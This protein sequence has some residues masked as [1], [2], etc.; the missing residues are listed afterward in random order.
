MMSNLPV[1][2]RITASLVLVAVGLAVPGAPAAAAL[3]TTPVVI[4]DAD[5]VPI[6]LDI[7][8]ASSTSDGQR[9][10]LL[11]ETHGPSA[12][13]DTFFTWYL[14]TDDDGTY[15]H[16]VEAGFDPDVGGFRG[17]VSPRRGSAFDPVDTRR[18][19][20]STMAVVVPLARIGDPQTLSYQVLGAEDANGDLLLSDGELD[21]AGIDGQG[22]LVVRLGGPD[23]IATSVVVSEGTF[24]DHGAQ[25]VVLAVAD[26][27]AD[28]LAGAPLAGA[29]FGPL[30]LTGGSSLD[31]RVEDEIRRVLAPG[32][33]VYLL[34]GTGV[35]SPAIAD[36]LGALGYQVTRY[37]GANR[38]ETAIVIA[39]QGLDNPPTLLLSTGTA[40]VDGLS[41]G[42]AAAARGGALLL[43][44]GAT[45][46]PAVAAYLQAHPA[47]RRFAVGG[48]AAAADPSAT[49]VVGANRYD[50]SRLVASLFFPDPDQ[51]GVTT[52]EAFP[53]ALSGGANM[54]LFGGPLLV[55]PPGSLASEVAEYLRAHAGT[56]F[57]GS[58]F[59]GRL[60]VD[61]A[62]RTAVAT[63]IK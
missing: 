29:V 53:D 10:T 37:G 51:V 30:M 36:R 44:D 38:F 17:F 14:D 28:A 1:W 55:T 18:L 34:G 16:V 25:S 2:A 49:R 61:D 13:R 11:V 43:T 45:M 39:Q 5:D 6:S 4:A 48:P 22:D 7:R 47:A 42:A 21:V 26:N 62:V 58:V 59:G 46:P 19:S 15:D 63:A 31:P 35:L 8:T 60:A 33:P 24:P 12:D 27:F 41:A 23:R 20:P 54:A 56:V 9:L 32:G 57:V 52:G 3:P 40:F 50:T